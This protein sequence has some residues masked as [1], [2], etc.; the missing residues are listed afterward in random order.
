MGVTYATD[1]LKFIH[2]KC[3]QE[4][5]LS[6]DVK[7]SPLHLVMPCHSRHWLS[8]AC[9]VTCRYGNVLDEHRSWNRWCGGKNT[10]MV[11][12]DHENTKRNQWLKI[13]YFLIHFQQGLF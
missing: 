3:L 12:R 1:R 11:V 8:K 10:T 4:G 2:W 9:G 7:I 5:A 13:V 6:A